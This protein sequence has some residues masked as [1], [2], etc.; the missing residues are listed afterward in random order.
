ML[1]LIEKVNGSLVLQTKQSYEAA[2]FSFTRNH[3][4]WQISREES[5]NN[6]KETSVDAQ[7]SVHTSHHPSKCQT[8][9]CSGKLQKPQKTLKASISML[10]VEESLFTCSLLVLQPQELNI[11]V[12][13]LGIPKFSREKCKG[14]C[15]QIKLGWN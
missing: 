14:I 2:L 10:Y 4:S 8:V 3:H 1:P 6:F 11:W 12:E 5:S 7:Q 15:W 9:Q 13:L